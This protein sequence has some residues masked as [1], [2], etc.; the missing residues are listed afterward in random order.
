[1]KV[2]HKESR[3]TFSQKPSEIHFKGKH[4][5]RIYIFY[6]QPADTYDLCREALQ[7][8]RS[9][10]TFSLLPQSVNKTQRMKANFN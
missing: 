7:E 5:N 9:G 2:F 6:G 1:M 10:N 4:E 3:G 8:S